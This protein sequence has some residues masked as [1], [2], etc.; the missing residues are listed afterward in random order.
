MTTHSNGEKIL[1]VGVGGL[2]EHMVHEAHERG[3]QVSVMVR[4]RAKLDDRLAPATI[5]KLKKI[6][7]GDAT[8]PAAL[9]EGM[10]GIEVVL[11]GNGAHKKMAREMA[12]AVKRNRV[13]KLIWPAGGTNLLADDGITPA[14]KAYA[15]ASFNAEAI[16]KAH[17]ACIDAIRDVGV[18]YVIF[19]PGRMTPAGHRS[20]DVA[21]TVRVN[22][23]AGM[24]VSYE[25]A[26]WVIL[27]AA[28]TD[29]WDRQL[30]SAA[31]LQP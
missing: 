7:I 6:T 10:R 5:A 27:E 23:V 1:I 2:G 24:A 17:Q 4:D 21:S 3:A 13:G 8:D 14:Y 19:C 22:R 31:T 12:E 9:D 15:G 11:S 26:A 18:N 28:L 29:Q 25:D 30:I 16:Y 20:P